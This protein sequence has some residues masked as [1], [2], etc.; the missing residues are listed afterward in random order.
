MSL[1]G[2]LD[3]DV[4]HLHRPDDGPRPHGAR[5]RF[6]RGAR[7]GRHRGARP[8]GTGRGTVFCRTLP[9][10]RSGAPPRRRAA[11]AS[12]RV[13]RA[14]T[15]LPAGRSPG[16]VRGAARATR[17]SIR[18]EPA[19]RRHRSAPLRRARSTRRLLL[20]ASSERRSP[21]LSTRWPR[22]TTAPGCPRRSFTPTS[23]RGTPSPR[24]SSP[25][26][27][28]LD[29]G[30]PWSEDL[31]AGI[32]AKAKNPLDEPERPVERLLEPTVEPF[33]GSDGVIEVTSGTGRWGPRANYL[34]LDG[35]RL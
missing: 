12:H 30:G 32:P 1:H 22:P 4:Y 31:A 8:V 18:R 34:G 16:L 14:V 7:D 23:R 10:C 6:G 11:R 35:V 17:S 28:R 27:H 13:R 29:R 24:A 15:A 19:G 9:E 25:G 5:V 2:K 33:A 20:V 21:R 3:V 26:D